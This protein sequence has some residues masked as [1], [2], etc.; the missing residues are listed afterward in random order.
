MRKIAT[1]LRPGILDTLGLMYSIEWLGKEFERKNNIACKIELDMQ[2]QDV[3]KDISIC[4][5]R[6]CQEALT[7]IS[8]HAACSQVKITLQQNENELLMEIVD[9]GKG[10]QNEVVENTFSM[11][12]LG[13]RERATNIGSDLVVKSKKNEGTTISIKTL[14]N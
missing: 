10:I 1:E 9:N 6:I 8:K 12:M 14:M 7:N 11:G 13:M 3:R 2:E 4:F 5:F